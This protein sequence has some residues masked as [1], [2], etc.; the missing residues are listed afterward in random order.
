MKK[1]TVSPDFLECG[2]YC[3]IGTIIIQ[4]KA[5]MLLMALEA[6]DGVSY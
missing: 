4:I 3:I 6:C 2:A 1:L 5:A